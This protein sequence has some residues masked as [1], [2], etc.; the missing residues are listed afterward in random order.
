M[1]RSSIFRNE[2]RLRWKVTL[3]W[4]V[5]VVLFIYASMMKYA[6]FVGS[7]AS[8]TKL[9][10]SFPPTLQAV[11]GMTGLNLTTLTGYVG[12]TFL[13]LAVM[14][15]IF[16]GSLGAGVIAE[17]EQGKTAEFLYTRPVSRLRVFT[18][19]YLATLCM[20]SLFVAVFYGSILLS[21]ASYHPTSSDQHIFAL[22]A[23][24]ILLILVFFA[25]LGAVFA[26]V[27]FTAQRAGA[28][29]AVVATCAYFAYSLSDF[30]HAFVFLKRLSPLCW[31]AAPDII[32]SASLDGSYVIIAL[33]IAVILCVVALF[34]FLRRDLRA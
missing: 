8:S 30:M 17:E 16:A 6:A 27:K 15:A 22:F 10:S 28:L 34:S 2:L 5:A 26:S 7:G 33:L 32:E 3:G 11:F 31:F 23:F 18:E 13:Y 29:T 1:Y 20:I 12:L 25:A 21:T 14:A 9:L 19:K 24:A 4:L